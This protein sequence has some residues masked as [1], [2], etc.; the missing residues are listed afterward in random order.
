MLLQVGAAAQSELQSQYDFG[1]R[2]YD[3]EQYYDAITELKRLLFFDSLN[4]YSYTANKLIADCYKHGAKFGEAIKYYSLAEMHV[5]NSDSLFTIKIDIIK[6]NML[7]KT[8]YRAFDLLTD[9]SHDKRFN[10]RQMEI[11]YW[12]GWAYIF[13]NEWGKAA[14]EFSKIAD[15]HELKRLCENTAASEY[16]PA[17]AKILSYFLPGAGQL[18][19]GNI[20]S[21]LLSFG[22]VT[23]WTD[24]SIEAFAA[25]RIFDGILTANFLALRFYNGNLQNAEKFASEHNQEINNWML[26][27]LQNNYRGEKP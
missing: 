20:F 10:N 4:Q 17:K 25:E 15:N 22:W 13:A 2:L 23:L 1:K 16:S 27:Y 12:T 3:Q 5:P 19:T 7:R 11:I 8:V 26:N 18:Y 24:L 9:L 6:I 14:E 21:G